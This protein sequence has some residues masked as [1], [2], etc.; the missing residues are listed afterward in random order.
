MALGG[1]PFALALLAYN[2]AITGRP[3]MAVQVWA[4]PGREPLGAPTS[5]S[6]GE[7][8]VRLV[9]LY[10]W[11]SPILFIGW[12]LAFIA[13]A[14][15]KALSFV[16][17]LAPL[18]L[19]GFAFYG[20]SGGNQYGPRYYFEGIWFAL[21][22]AGRAIEPMLAAKTRRADWLAA[23]MVMHLVFQ[24]GYAI[25]RVARER[26]YI[27]ERQDMFVQVAKAGL[28]NAVVMVVDSPADF[29]RVLRILPARDMLRNG[30]EVGDED[31]TYA[32]DRGDATTRRLMARFPGRRFYRYYHGQLE[33]ALAPDGQLRPKPADA[34]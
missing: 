17:W 22:T 31:V 4:A 8:A 20:G 13:L 34:F 12:P 25:P 6:F 21:I 16:D 33:D 24:V 11:T 3:L 10:L 28:T 1:L 18:T 9:R 29:A 27:V 30:L 7:T 32:L 14:R 26:E 5:R 15:R 2:Q 23:A 19:V